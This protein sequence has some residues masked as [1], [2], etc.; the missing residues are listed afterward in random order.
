VA[1][2]LDEL[3][4]LA[5]RFKPDRVVFRDPVFAHDEERVVELCEGIMRR[6]I[7]LRWEC[8]SRP[9]HLNGSLL[10]LM[11]RAGCQWIKIGLETTDGTLLQSVGRLQHAHE[12]DAYLNQVAAVVSDCRSIGLNCRVFVMAGLA[13]QTE[14]SAQQTLRFLGQL[15]PGA[16]NV[17]ACE[18]YPG[19]AALAESRSQ[20]Q[21]QL[22]ILGRAESA[23]RQ[24]QSIGLLSRVKRWLRRQLGERR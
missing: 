1:N 24:A 13:G 20:V 7:T 12:V 4:W 9:E 14:Q 17:K 11:Q 18:P 10:R 15:R 5:D 8:E 6:G 3:G 22:D 19:T 21:A 2:V 16:L 23:V